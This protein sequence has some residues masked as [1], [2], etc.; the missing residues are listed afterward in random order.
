MKIAFID[1]I[2]WDYTPLTPR[3][4]P[5]GGSQ[6][7]LCYLATSLA[8]QGHEVALLNNTAAPG[9]YAGVRCTSFAA[10]IDPAHLSSR[11]A[12]VVLNGAMG[13]QLRA[14]GVKS[15]LVLWSQ[16][17]ADQS[18]IAA[19]KDVNERLAWD[20]FFLVSEWQARSY[21]QAF[22]I[23]PERIT[24]VRNAVSPPFQR[25]ERRREPFFL[26]GEPPVLFYTS[27]PFRGLWL[28]LSAF[29]AIAKA[30]PGAR[31][32]VFSSMGVY[33]VTG[34]ADEYGVLYDLARALPGVEYVGSLP[35]AELAEALGAAD[36]LAYPN[37]FA[38]TSCIAAMEAMAAGA[39]LLTTKLGALPETTAGFAF[40]M[41]VSQD[42]MRMVRDFARLTIAVA[43]TARQ[44]P[45][46]FESIVA[47]ERAHAR[48]AY[49]W[50]GRA[51]EWATALERLPRRS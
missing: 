41:E 50:T 39:L 45:Q 42:S 15:R 19:L 48:A 16:H 10:G 21:A 46:E 7:A 43:E 3:E 51:R 26:T 33:Q 1:P 35:Q 36:I 25:L 5:L 17:A 8:E 49:D 30:I 27:T 20:G 2:P 23:R 40:T 44:K 13:K 11:D 28:L 29:P 34:D 18:A 22:G 12:V 24:I 4:R 9:D 47:R 31:L 37:V 32:Q 38:E 6:S 14:A